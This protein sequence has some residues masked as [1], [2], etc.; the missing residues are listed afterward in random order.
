MRSISETELCRTKV[1]TVA[2]VSEVTIW[3]RCGYF[4]HLFTQNPQIQEHALMQDRSQN[5]A[6]SIHVNVVA[7]SSFAFTL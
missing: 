3:D 6:V 5:V 7:R 1:L 4:L 2:N